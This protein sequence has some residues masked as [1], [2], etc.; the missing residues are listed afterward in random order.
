MDSVRDDERVVR[1]TER[2]ALARPS[3][4]CGSAG[5]PT[6]YRSLLQRFA[7]DELVEHISR[8]LGHAHATGVGDLPELVACALRRRGGPG[9]ARR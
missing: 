1:L 5:S 3:D 2:E 6:R 7:F 4:C 9:S 8:Q